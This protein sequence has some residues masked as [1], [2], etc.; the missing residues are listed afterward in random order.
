MLIL[1]IGAIFIYILVLGILASKWPRKS[2]RIHSGGSGHKQTVVIPFRDELYNL[3]TLIDSLEE[4]EPAEVLFVNDRSTDSGDLFLQNEIERRSLTDWRVIDS[5]GIG[6]KDA[7]E[8]GV[9][10]AKH[11]VVLVTDADC[12]LPK[13]WVKYMTARFE[14][15]NVKMVCG[16]VLPTMGFGWL[17]KFELGEWASILLVTNFGFAVKKPLMCSAANMGYKKEAFLE[18]GGYEDNKDILSGDDE[19]LLKKIERNWGSESILWDPSLDLLVKTKAEASWESLLVQR[20]RWAS[21]WSV[22]KNW[23]DKLPPMIMTVFSILF[24]FSFSLLFPLNE[25]SRYFFVIWIFKGLADCYY[26]GKGLNHYLPQFPKSTL[27]IASAIHP[28]YTLLIVW[29]VLFTTLYWKGRAVFPTLKDE[30]QHV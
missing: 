19:F 1:Y 20:A 21:K 24:L 11:D 25:N 12:I 26:L 29:K 28:V 13:H 8:L 18:V 6:K 5:H 17:G 3:P 14:F 10:Q 16:P 2:L 4:N 15:Q 27:L 7:V 23:V 30:K 9:A 22:N